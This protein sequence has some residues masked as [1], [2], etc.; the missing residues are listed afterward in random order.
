[1]AR[2]LLI[3]GE[4]MV[5]VKGNVTTQISGLTELGLS[6][7]QIRIRPN[8]RYLDIMVNAWG[9]AFPIDVQNML[10]DVNITMTLVHYDQV[11]LDICLRESMGGAA[12]FGTLPRA[13]SRLGGGVARFAAG[14][15]YV[16]LN[17]ASPVNNKPYRFYFAYLDGP[18]IELP[19]GT[20]R[21]LVTCNWRAVPY[22]VDPW[23]A[24]VG[25]LGTVI[26]DNIL[27]V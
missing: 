16:G 9:N 25:S 1:M 20:E 11:V 14:N 18:P 17:L 6:S 19:L 7:D 4:T 22:T 24:G 27:D 15:H 13:G 2:D 5:Y 26:F 8:F 12:A 10:T 21:S 23:N 3:N